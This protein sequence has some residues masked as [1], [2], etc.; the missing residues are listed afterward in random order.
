[1]RLI[2]LE[3][4][5]RQNDEENEKWLRSE[6]LIEQKWREQQRKV[7]EKMRREEDERNRIAAERAA[8][9]KKKLDLAEEKARVFA[10]KIERERDL[11][12][13]I[14]DYLNDALPIPDE[15]NEIA[16][17]NPGKQ[18]CKFFANTA[19]CRFGL[20]C[21]WNHCRPKI[22]RTLLVHSFFTNIRLDQGDAN[23]YGADLSLEFDEAQLFRD[24]CNFFDDALSEFRKF[25]PIT[26]VVTCQNYESHMRGNVYIEYESPR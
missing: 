26:L 19:T 5:Q 21:A 24:Y 13:R 1:M 16:E 20:K 22:S 25:G 8:E 2:E 12:R 17:S 9:V 23:E 11:L 14:N 4:I 7:E 15:L 18:T 6:L 10:E 3:N